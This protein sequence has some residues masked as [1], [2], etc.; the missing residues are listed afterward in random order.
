MESESISSL[1]HL[2]YYSHCTKIKS[3]E[4]GSWSI[5]QHFYSV[6]N[7]T[8]AHFIVPKI[9]KLSKIKRRK[10]RTRK[11]MD[12]EKR[13]ESDENVNLIVEYLCMTLNPVRLLCSVQFF[14]HH[15]LLSFI[16]FGCVFLFRSSNWNDIHLLRF[17]SM[18]NIEQSECKLSYNWTLENYSVNLQNLKAKLIKSHY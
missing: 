11:I 1:L 2:L 13:V 18:K 3:N 12:G 6:R 9:R 14:F 4:K 15:A 17:V 7:K 10:K 16:L 5:L 8:W